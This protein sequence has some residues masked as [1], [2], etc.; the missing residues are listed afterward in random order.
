MPAFAMDL[1]MTQD[2]TTNQ[3]KAGHAFLLFAIQRTYRLA[4]LTYSLKHL[5]K[6]LIAIQSYRSTSLGGRTRKTL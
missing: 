6:R 4:L 2:L 1:A 5:L 3:Q